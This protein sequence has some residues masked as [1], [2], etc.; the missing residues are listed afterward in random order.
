MGQDEACGGDASDS[1]LT[2]RGEVDCPGAGSGPEDHLWGRL[3]TPDRG[4]TLVR[5]D[6]V[7]EVLGNG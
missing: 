6:D 4:D 1:V 7:V 3:S 5:A 2:A